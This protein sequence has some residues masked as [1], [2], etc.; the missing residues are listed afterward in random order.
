MIDYN[1]TFNDKS[2]LPFF[3]QPKK[4]QARGPVQFCHNLI[5]N[6][7]KKGK[8]PCK[9]E[10]LET[11]IKRQI[12]DHYLNGICQTTSDYGIFTIDH[13]SPQSD[14]PTHHIQTD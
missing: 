11:R 8:S 7:F 5:V 4:D 1:K 13:L 9:Q 6:L 14:L 2:I 3:V 10:F 12:L